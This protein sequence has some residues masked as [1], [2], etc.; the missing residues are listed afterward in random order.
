MN[1]AVMRGLA[2]V[3]LVGS[4]GVAACEDAEPTPR[5]TRTRTDGAFV[6]PAEWTL[7]AAEMP[8][9][10]GEPLAAHHTCDDTRGRTCATVL[11]WY[12]EPLQRVYECWIGYSGTSRRPPVIKLDKEFVEPAARQP[13]AWDFAQHV[14]DVGRERMRMLLTT[15]TK[16]PV[17]AM[18]FAYSVE[19]R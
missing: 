6:P 1:S 5:W 11:W 19:T 16:G 4:F 15:T 7:G 18:R 8:A 17:P 3:V 12:D 14:H 13:R 9:C 10:T 2:A